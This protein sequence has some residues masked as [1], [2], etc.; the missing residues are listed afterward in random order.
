[1]TAPSGL[2][3]T[4]RLEGK[5]LLTT[6]STGTYPSP[7]PQLKLPITS[8]SKLS[9]LFA[10]T[11]LLPITANIDHA[12]FDKSYRMA[13]RRLDGCLIRRFAVYHGSVARKAAHAYQLPFPAYWHGHSSL[14]EETVEEAMYKKDDEWWWK[15]AARTE[16]IVSG[17]PW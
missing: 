6:P 5:K 8:I 9:P 7:R 3:A 1:V 14:D 13:T 15:R 12:R 10:S 17:Y 11:R 2:R 4:I 16:E